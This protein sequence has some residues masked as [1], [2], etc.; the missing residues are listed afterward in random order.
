MGGPPHTRPVALATSFLAQAGVP[1]MDSKIW[2]SGSPARSGTPHHTRRTLPSLWI[3]LVAALCCCVAPCYAAAKN[4]GG[5][6]NTPAF[7]ARYWKTA[8]FPTGGP[9]NLDD[10]ILLKIKDADG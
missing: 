6:S 8:E 5:T 9:L 7:D 1:P 3:L 4:Q 10:M 2:A